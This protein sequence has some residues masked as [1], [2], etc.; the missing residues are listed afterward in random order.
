MLIKLHAKCAVNPIN[1]AAV[2]CGKISV[3][4]RLTNGRTHNIECRG[5]GT[6]DALFS[7]I[8]TMLFDYIDMIEVGAKERT[9]IAV[10][11]VLSIAEITPGIAVNMAGDFVVTVPAG[12]SSKPMHFDKLV[13]QL[14]AFK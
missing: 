4:I 13:R 7:S 6:C 10:D 9:L 12:M 1:V 8:G 2:V 14:E 5:N 11:H 3:G